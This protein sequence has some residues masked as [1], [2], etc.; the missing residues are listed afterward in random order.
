[1]SESTA[2]QG[3]VQVL[4]DAGIDKVFGI[5]GGNLVVR[6][7][8]VDALAE[9]QDEIRTVLVREESLGSVMAEVY[10]RLTGKPGVVFAQGA[11]LLANSAM[12]TLEAHLSSSPMLLIGDYTDGGPFSHHAVYQ[13][14]SGDYGSWDARLAFRAFT[15]A[16]FSPFYPSQVAHET[17]LAI[18]HAVSGEPGPV[19]LLLHSSTLG[20]P[21]ADVGPRLYPTAKYLPSLRMAADSADVARAARLLADAAHPVIIAGNGVR[22]PLAFRGLAALSEAMSIPVATTTGGKGSFVETDELALGVIGTFGQAVANAVV[23]A[24]DVV[25]VV[26]S[27]LGASDTANEHLDLIDPERQTLIQIDIEPRNLSWTYPIDVPLLGDCG[28]VLDQLLQEVDG[29][30]RADGHGK[31]REFVASAKREHGF[32]NEPERLSDAAPLLP[33]RIIQEL[34]RAG[35]E[36]AI[37]CLDAGENRIFMTH[38]FQTKSAGTLIQASGVGGMGYAIPAAL[39]AKAVYPDRQVVA[40]C[41]DGGF[42]M[43][44]NGLMT[45]LEENLS[46]VTVV[47]NN[48]SLGWVKHDLAER[49][50]VIAAEFPD[51]DHAAIARAMGCVGVRVD[52]PAELADALQTALAS[53]KPAVVDVATSLDESFQSIMSPLVAGA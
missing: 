37:L 3:L 25:L 52:H 36:D 43:T 9:R 26:G 49:G 33:Q 4:I 1:M 34:Q 29:G 42:A 17:Q 11:W 13:S 16:V 30:L 24:A 22:T 8:L 45:A 10:G 2:A 38:Y 40:V 46:I 41:G 5:P 27:H 7:G 15:K 23:G 48:H 28:T 19:A 12:G 50:P 6:N 31:R 14:G 21:S 51:Y 39:G 18:K 32:F 35:P 44:M 53:D 20:D 47:L